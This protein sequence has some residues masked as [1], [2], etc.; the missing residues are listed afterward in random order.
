MKG[1]ALTN[2]HQKGYAA[3]T[4]TLTLPLLLLF[5]S[6]LYEIVRLLHANSVMVNLARESSHLV[7]R[8]ADYTVQEIMDI[9]ATTSKV[10]DMGENGIIYI[11]HVSGQE[12][13]QPF[14]ADQ[15]RWLQAGINDE[16]DLWSGCVQWQ[17]GECQMPDETD[18]RE[19]T[20]F[21]LNL[22]QNDSAYVVEVFYRYSPFF[23]LIGFDDILLSQRTY[24]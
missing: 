1:M 21:P 9:V 12:D 13:D 18:I 10:V 16:S 24:L 22:E 14:V 5:I 2:T 15:H 20:D 3:V 11:S 7:S 4:F 8:T 6:G 17:T 23:G 19:L